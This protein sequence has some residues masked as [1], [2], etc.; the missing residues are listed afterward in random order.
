M[1][2]T[3]KFNEVRLAKC[4]FCSSAAE[5]HK[6]E[7]GT[8][9]V[10]CG[11]C[12]Y[13]TTSDGREAY[14]NSDT[15]REAARV[16][17]RNYFKSI[18]QYELGGVGSKEWEERK[19]GMALEYNRQIEE[20]AKIA[21]SNFCENCSRHYAKA[22]RKHQ[23]FAD[24]LFYECENY[25]KTKDAA[26]AIAEDDLNDERQDLYLAQKT[27]NVDSWSLISCEILEAYVAHLKGDAAATVSELYDAVAVLM[28]M[29]AV[30]EGKQKLGGER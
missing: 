7:D 14:I 21:P 15:L 11:K 2:E 27:A 22:L 3:I 13:R 12:H 25:Y 30:V 20:I 18:G 29:I 8:Y 23:R 16:W 9:F 1:S 10:M 5:M 28:R 24:K 26:L 19:Y 17:N 4:I 6:N